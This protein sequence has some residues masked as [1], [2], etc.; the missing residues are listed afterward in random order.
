MN[1]E[2]SLKPKASELERILDRWERRYE[3]RMLSRSVPRSLIA[4][5]LLS[6]VAGFIG[7]WRLRAGAEQLALVAAGLCALGFTL[8]LL[9]TLLF[10]RKLAQRA[11]YFDLEF[12]LK[13]R[14]STALELMQGRITTSPEIE[15]RQIA[16][17]LEHA[18]AIDPVERIKMDF[19][20]RELAVLALLC[21]A[22]I[23]MLLLPAVFGADFIAEAPPAA[24]EEARD[25]LREMIEAAAKDSGMD[26][27]DRQ[28]LLEALEIALERLEEEAVSEEEAFAAMSQLAAQLEEMARQL[29]EGMELD[30][31]ASE[32]ALESLADYLPPVDAAQADSAR[33][34]G[35]ENAADLQDMLSALE[36]MEQTAPEMSAEESQRAADALRQAAEALEASSPEMAERLRSMAEAMES[37]DMES[38]NEA[39][40]SLADELAQAQESQEQ[41]RNARMTLQE[42]ADQA[43]AGAEAIAQDQAM[44]GQP[45]SGGPQ[46]GQPDAAQ[47][48]QQPGSQS[49]DDADGAQP[50]AVGG[51][52][53]AERNRPGPEGGDS[54]NQDGRS[55][56]A[57]A[58]EGPPSN[59]SLPGSGGVDRGAET[60]NRTTG[61][62]EIEYEALYSP[63][64]IE[65]G[66]QNEIRLR[67]SPGDT[68]LAEGEFDDNPAGE[69]R[70][71]YDTVFSDY[72]N[73]ANRAL[74]SDY[75]PL[76][77]RDVVRDYFTSLEPTG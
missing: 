24:V 28:E 34:D 52:Q 25:E 22:V 9:Q 51:D 16:E 33:S 14:V 73:A 77:L 57:G 11:R 26:D 49:G 55:A 59:E 75:V 40:D 12:G 4:A 68:T 18:R 61:R 30:Q 41:E 44:Q 67:A 6:L 27:I 36:Q 72:Q 35:A 56:G 32:A 71:S 23:G 31:R 8:N 13:E 47:A 42:Q 5:L 76:G 29:E 3:W 37:G 1:R 69:S 45:E 50:G 38:L 43:E 2:Q 21:V 54:R 62:G 53:P 17:T 70:V 46:E 74:E 20:R 58:G 19:R 48:G 66:G 10:P 64:G 7:Y 60:D 63:S 65:G 15:A 39:M